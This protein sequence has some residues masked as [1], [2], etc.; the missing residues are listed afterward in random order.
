MGRMCKVTRPLSA[1]L[2]LLN[3]HMLRKKGISLETFQDSLMLFIMQWIYTLY[4]VSFRP[5]MEVLRGVVGVW[6]EI[7]G[8]KCA[9]WRLLN[10]ELLNFDQTM[11][12]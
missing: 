7:G 5:S 10:F 9:F 3:R 1:V 6:Q 11:E 12:I 4:C 2:L 8:E